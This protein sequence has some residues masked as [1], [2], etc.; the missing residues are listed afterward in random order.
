MAEIK[1]ALVNDRMCPGRALVFWRGEA[2]LDVQ[3]LGCGL[4]QQNVTPIVA[5]DKMAVRINNAT[6][7]NLQSSCTHQQSMKDVLGLPSNQKQMKAHLYS[8]DSLR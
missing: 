1:L 2:S 5:I 4:D 3:S 8:C 7:L 6:I